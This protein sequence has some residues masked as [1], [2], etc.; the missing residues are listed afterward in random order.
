MTLYQTTVVSLGSA[1][2]RWTVTDNADFEKNV[3]VT[4]EEWNSVER[5]WKVRQ[6]LDNIPA[7]VLKM[8]G[9]HA[10]NITSMA[11]VGFEV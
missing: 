4:Y 6:K 3:D 1:D 9:E 5:V 10:E 8:L 2:W 11:E 7:K